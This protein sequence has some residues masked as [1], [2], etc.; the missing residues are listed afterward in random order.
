MV[1]AGT[2]TPAPSAPGSV[3]V[4]MDIPQGARLSA[5]AVEKL[6]AQLRPILQRMRASEV[7]PSAVTLA[8]VAAAVPL[9]Q[10]HLAQ[11]CK[12][13]PT[14]AERAQVRA[15]APAGADVAKL[16]AAAIAKVRKDEDARNAEFAQSLQLILLLLTAVPLLAAQ[17]ERSI[18]A[19][20]RMPVADGLTALAVA[21]KSIGG[22]D[23]MQ[24]IT[25]TIKD[26]LPPAAEA[27]R[28]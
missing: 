1:A 15:N 2:E 16:E 4:R 11:P 18:D 27:M 20:W 13:E 10:I 14:N 7:D 17:T 26:A 8:H 19:V 5:E 9:L 25:L 22:A 28:G 24:R 23:D 12:W 6:A 3:T 21:L